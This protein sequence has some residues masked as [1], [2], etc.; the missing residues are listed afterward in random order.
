ME[1]GAGA[2]DAFPTA[3]EL[4]RFELAMKDPT[5]RR[6]WQQY[7]TAMS[8]PA[9]RR[10]ELERLEAAEEASELAHPAELPDSVRAEPT[11]CLKGSEIDSMRKVFVNICSCPSAPPT[12]CVCWPRTAQDAKGEEVVIMDVA[13]P[14]EAFEK[15]SVVEDALDLVREGGVLLQDAVK[16]LQRPYYGSEPPWPNGVSSDSCRASAQAREW[17]GAGPLEKVATD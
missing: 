12:G 11:I 7:V 4:A 2:A 8:D 15:E 9:F 10:R 17:L 14:E 5:L 13:F 16:K 6:L 1:S 3:E